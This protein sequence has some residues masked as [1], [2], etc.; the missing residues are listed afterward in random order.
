M[1]FDVIYFVKGAC[2]VL[3]L[4]H[5]FHHIWDSFDKVYREPKL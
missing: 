1:A 3:K 4:Y 5:G 2:K